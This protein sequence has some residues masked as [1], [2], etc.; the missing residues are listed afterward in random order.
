MN[1]QR[2]TLRNVAADQEHSEREH[3][4]Q[5]EG[6]PPAERGIDF[7]PIQQPDGEQRT[8]DRAHPERAVDHNV[9]PASIVRRYQLVD[10]GVDGGAAP[11][12]KRHAKYQAGLGAKAVSTVA[13]V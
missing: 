13:T 9:H 6:Q 1:S 10:R 7:G 3:R 4:A 2:G 8:T 12:K 5:S 11:V